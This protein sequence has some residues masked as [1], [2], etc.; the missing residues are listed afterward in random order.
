MVEEDLA[1]SGFLFSSEWFR[2]LTDLLDMRL[3]SGPS[4]RIIQVGH[5][6]EDLIDRTPVATAD[7]LCANWKDTLPY[8]TPNRLGTTSVTFG[9]SCNVKP[10]GFRH[11]YSPSLNRQADQMRRTTQNGNAFAPGVRIRSLE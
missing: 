2:R 1:N 11:L 6:D 8:A 3:A 5:S 4:K 10:F 9:S 7:L